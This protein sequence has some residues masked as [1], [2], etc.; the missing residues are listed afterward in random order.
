[1]R[2]LKDKLAAAQRGFTLIELVIVIVIIGILAAVAIPQF[3]NVTDDANSGVANAAVGAIRSAISARSAQCQNPASTL[4]PGG[5][6]CPALTCATAY[7]L[8][9]PPAGAS[10]TG[11]SPACTVTVG[12]VVSTLTYNPTT[13]S[14]T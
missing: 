1:M 12:A 2:I 6:A 10:A 11:T 4:R 14:G 5:A 7:A 8:I 9:T 13:A 3:A